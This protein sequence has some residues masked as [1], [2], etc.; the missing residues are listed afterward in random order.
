I[1][2][3]Q[4]VGRCMHL[5]NYAGRPH[6]KQK[7]NY[8]SCAGP[9]KECIYPSNTMKDACQSVTRTTVRMTEYK[10]RGATSGSNGHMSIVIHQL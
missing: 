6:A 4:L 7:L 9:R 2:F 10:G 1:S 3:L 5:P 8:W